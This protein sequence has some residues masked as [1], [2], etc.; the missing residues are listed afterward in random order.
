MRERESGVVG[1]RQSTEMEQR[2]ERESENRQDREERENGDRCVRRF[3]RLICEKDGTR[4]I[5][6]GRSEGNETTTNIHVFINL[7]TNKYI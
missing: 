4:M 2:E 7:Y 5:R 3:Q 1:R 6:E